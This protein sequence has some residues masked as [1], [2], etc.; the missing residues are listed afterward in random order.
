MFRRFLPS[1]FVLALATTWLFGQS[2]G[3]IQGSVTDP[4]GAAVPKAV[5]TLRNVDTGVERNFTTDESGLY[6]IP[7]LPVGRYQITAKATGL[8]VTTVNDL[9]LED[10][11]V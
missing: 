11:I 3:V 6:V 10:S 9:I 8:Q 1:I 5:V 4:S 2:T 7:S